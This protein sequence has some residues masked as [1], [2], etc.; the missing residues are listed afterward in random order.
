MP[1]AY[2]QHTRRV[3][4]LLLFA[5]CALTVLFASAEHGISF[6]PAE[7]QF[8]FSGPFSRRQVL[9][10]KI[11]GNAPTNIATVSGLDLPSVN[12]DV[13]VVLGAV[14]DRLTWSGRGLR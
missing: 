10:Y 12:L 5:Y 9:A 4:P 14:D 7:V 8:L 2:A 11:V 13:D 3:G 6:T 1:L